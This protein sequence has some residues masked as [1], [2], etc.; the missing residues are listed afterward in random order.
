MEILG[1]G[2]WGRAELNPLHSKVWVF[3]L[4]EKIKGRESLGQLQRV[5]QSMLFREATAIGFFRSTKV[6][7]GGSEPIY[8]NACGHNWVFKLPNGIDARSKRETNE[9]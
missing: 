1:Q 6:K 3:S 7:L 5:L 2:K 4:N 9:F 8:L